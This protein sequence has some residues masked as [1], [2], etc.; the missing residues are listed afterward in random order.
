VRDV[1]RSTAE[2]TATNPILR[3]GQQGIESDTLRAKTGDGVTPWRT[4][5]YTSGPGDAVTSSKLWIGSGNPVGFTDLFNRANS[6]TTLGS[7][8]SAL[9]GVWG[10]NGNA[11]Y[12]VSGV[13]SSTSVAAVDGGLADGTV[14]ATMAAAAVAG[15][16]HGIAF[17]VVDASNFCALVQTTTFGGWVLRAVVAGSTVSSTFVFASYAAGTVIRLDLTGSSVAV[18]ANGTLISTVTLPYNLE[19]TKVGFVAPNGSSVARW[20]S[21][22][23]D[24]GLTGVATG[25][26]YL[27]KLGG[28]LFGPYAAG[29]PATPAAR[30]NRLPG[31]TT[32]A[33]P[34]AATLGAR[35]PYYDLTLNKPVWSD[36]T[37][38]RDATGTTV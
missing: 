8:W 20:D 31:F 7:P 17:R 35:T 21:I 2:F 25:H 27:D 34:S 36:G 32:A 6:T 23:V 29:W 14:T 3:A 16:E 22:T 28:G 1:V 10:I 12:P 11:A 24:A 4:L 33:R 9:V 18:R 13:G 37:V 30:T 5:A 15:N 26:Y 19:A 38:Y